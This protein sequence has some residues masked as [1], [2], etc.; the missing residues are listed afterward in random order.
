M[1]C[2]VLDSRKFDRLI[3]IEHWKLDQLTIILSWFRGTFDEQKISEKKSAVTRGLS[4]CTVVSFLSIQCVCCL[5]SRSGPSYCSVALL[6][7]SSCTCAL[8][9]SLGLLALTGVW[10][11]KKKLDGDVVQLVRASDC[12]A[13]DTGSIPRWGQGI[14]VPE[15][16]F[17]ADSLTCVRT[18]LCAIICIN[19]F[20][21]VK[22]F[23]GLCTVDW[24][25][26]LSRSWL[27]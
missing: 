17:S 4:S 15:S 19:I 14:F 21:H 2:A 10:K 27:S 9:Q 8:H 18:P 12:H 1:S 11:K 24:V 13:A 22:E 6:S 25:A 20:A 26:W 23:G 5:F 7:C 16:T 3:A